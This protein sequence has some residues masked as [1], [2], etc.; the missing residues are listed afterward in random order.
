MKIVIVGAGFSGSVISENLSRRTDCEITVIDERLHIGGNC[1]T[2][3][4]ETTGV[5]EH[6]YGPHI[7][8]TD[9]IKVWEYVNRFCEMKPFVNRVKTVAGGAVYTF[10]INLHTT[11]Q[12]FSKIFSPN[13]AKKFIFELGDA[14]ISEPKNFEQQAL[15]M[16]GEDLYHTFI[17]GYTKKQWGCEP[18]ELPASI[19]K[20]LPVRF[21][22]DDNYY[23]SPLQ[24]SS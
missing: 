3:V 8:Y 22:Y 20:R 15:K 14:S 1:Y 12:F 19:L 2:E 18:Y 13:E 21:N 6:K 4:D 9:N 17:Y 23:T 10:A 11:N 7:F 16:L 5:T 24:G